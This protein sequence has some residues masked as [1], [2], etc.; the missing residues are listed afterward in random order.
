MGAASVSGEMVA[1][2]DEAGRGALAG[3]LYVASVI[4][5]QDFHHPLLR[6]SKTLTSGQRAEM[7]CLIQ[8][9]AIAYAIVEVS[10]EE[11]DRLNVLRATLLGM[12]RAVE[13]LPVRPSL[14]RIDGP[15]APPL[16]GYRM[17]THVD[18]DALWPE[19]AAASILAKTARDACM[20]NLH[21]RYPQ[22]HWA[23]NK[24]YPTSQHRE[25]LRLYGPSPYHRRSFLKR[26]LLKDK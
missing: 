15:H 1:G 17:E 2:V 12:A 16:G 13:A 24:G 26:L 5:P 3:P 18:G 6:D 25:A 19:I 9:V 20:E 10:L 22:Y 21:Q 8:E 23:Q 7:A 11:I 4:L 14:V